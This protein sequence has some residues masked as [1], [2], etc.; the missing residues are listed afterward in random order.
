MKVRDANGLVFWMGA[1]RL[2]A[3]FGGEGVYEVLERVA[4][5][6]LVGKEYEPLWGY[7]GERRQHGCFRVL[8][9][10]YVTADAGTCIVHTAPGFGA[11][12][13]RLCV[14]HGL[15]KPDTPPVPIDESGHFTA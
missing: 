14:Q 6:E 11:D 12:D 8:P 4:G 2:I 9:A 1:D 13:Y 10:E 15:I 3:L 7:F 5:R